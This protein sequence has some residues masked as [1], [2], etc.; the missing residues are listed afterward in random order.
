SECTAALTP[1]ESHAFASESADRDA[2]R[3][4]RR[5]TGRSVGVVLSGGGAR[6]FAHIGVLDELVA[7][8]V[9]ID[10]VAGVSMGAF[11]GALFAMGMDPSEIDALCFEEWVQRRP[12]GDYTLPRSS[13][14]RGDRVRAMLR[15]CFDGIAIEE[16]P[17][18]FLCGC[19]ELRSGSLVLSRSGSLYESVSFS[20]AVPVLGAP[21]VRGRN[22]FVDGSLVD[23]LP[24]SAMAEMGEGPI[25]AVDVKAT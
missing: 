25:I 11:I 21:Q 15:R 6:A 7:A 1:I 9:E 23:N 5:L 20:I 17:L 10:R 16:L 13:L 8:G 18:S 14:I 19:A 12:L 3:I 22:L 24:V 4:A 2:E